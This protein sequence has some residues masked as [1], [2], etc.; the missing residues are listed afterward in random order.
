[1][2]PKTKVD[3]YAAI[4]DRLTFD[5]NLIQ[6]PPTPTASPSPKPPGTTPA[7]ELRPLRP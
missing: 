5:G 2:P 4:V 6:T 7:V 1:M 3:L